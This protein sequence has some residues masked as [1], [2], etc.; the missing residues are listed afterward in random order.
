MAKRHSTDYSWVCDRGADV[1]YFTIIPDR[2][3]Y[4]KEV[5]SG[6]YVRYD[7]KSHELVGI[8]VLNFSKKLQ[9]DFKEVKVP[10]HVD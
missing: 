7:A 2:V 9:T 1:L 3:A 6:V 4:A 5:Q 10:A 8:T